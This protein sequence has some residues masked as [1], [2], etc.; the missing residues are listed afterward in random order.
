[1][2]VPHYT[3]VNAPSSILH[4]GRDVRAQYTRVAARQ[5]AAQLNRFAGRLAHQLRARPQGPG[6]AA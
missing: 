2:T 1:M 3:T 5:A 6:Q 4:N